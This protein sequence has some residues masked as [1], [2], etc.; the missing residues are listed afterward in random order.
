MGLVDLHLNHH[1]RHIGQLQQVLLLADARALLNEDTGADG[2]AGG[3]D[4]QPFLRRVNLGQLQLL[5]HLREALALEVEGVELRVHVRLVGLDG[6]GGLLL[7][8]QQPEACG[9]ERGLKLANGLGV[10]VFDGEA[11]FLVGLL[12]DDFLPLHRERVRFQLVLGGVALG[13][14]RLGPV[15]A[16]LCALQLFLRDGDF[17][18][19]GAPSLRPIALLVFLEVGDG[20]LDLQ[21]SVL[22]GGVHGKL[23]N[24]Q[25]FLGPAVG[26]LG[27]L[28]GD[29]LVR[30]LLLQAGGVQFHQQVALLHRGALGH[31]AHDGGAAL[32][33]VADDEL[34]HGAQRAALDER[35]EE[36]VPLHGM[37][38][39][40][41]DHRLAA[42]Q[43]VS[44]AANRGEE[45]QQQP[46][47]PRTDE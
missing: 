37:V 44:R 36:V 30:E 20:E 26:S 6:G 11:F 31:D 14:E 2:T 39:V 9:V 27:V 8:L 13:L 21:H 18:L 4:D 7:D 17:G 34:L 32:Q 43:R 3:I 38:A 35:D 10:S 25:I 1:L 16:V 42:A 41:G 23:L 15:E 28:H 47:R 33:L 24:L 22:H 29:L 19:D 45:E 40:R 5:L 12:D 46:H